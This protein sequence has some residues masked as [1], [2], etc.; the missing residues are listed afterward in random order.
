MAWNLEVGREKLT[1]FALYFVQK[2]TENNLYKNPLF[3]NDPARGPDLR[4]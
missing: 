3:S 1:L 2:F 4:K